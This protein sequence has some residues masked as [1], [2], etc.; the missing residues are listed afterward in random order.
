MYKEYQP[1]ALLFPYIETYWTSDN[2]GGEEIS[3]RI[4]PD[5]CVD[6][7]FTFDKTEQSFFTSIIGT[8]TS[9]L[10]VNYPQTV[11]IFGIRFRP[12]G[13][14]AFTKV[15]VAEFTDLEVDLS[16]VET[17]LDKSF[18][19]TLPQKQTVKE[20][21][22]HIDNY[23]INRIPYLYSCDKQIVRAVDL[24][25]LANGQASPAKIASDVCLCQRHFER[26][27]KAAI[28]V[29][30]KMFAKVVRFKN[31]LQCLRIRPNQDI[32]SVA[33]NCG[34]Y[35]HTHLIKDFRMFS[36]DTPS[37]LRC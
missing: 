24:I 5:G 16:L 31:A 2:F 27:F 21:V 13:I 8:M 29:S 26:K 1:N 20:I 10:E 7:I 36:G 14:T 4:L 32:L 33:L 34:Y 28:G 9:F 37:D 18:Y 19:E 12:A 22:T 25:C 3:G 35:D 23:L 11:Q 30:P 17:L 6:I 15:C